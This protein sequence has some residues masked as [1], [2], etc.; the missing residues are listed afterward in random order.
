MRIPQHRKK[1]AGNAPVRTPT[2]KFVLKVSR[3]GLDV[4]ASL[5]TNRHSRPPPEDRAYS[6]RSLLP[7]Y[8][9][10]SCSLYTGDDEMAPAEIRQRMRDTQGEQPQANRKVFIIECIRKAT[11]PWSTHQTS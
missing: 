11:G 4:I 2:N 6:A 5:V 7:K 8:T 9:I 10:L 1:T 3:A